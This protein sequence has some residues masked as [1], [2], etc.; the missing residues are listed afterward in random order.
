MAPRS[1]E[2]I[3]HCQVL[4]SGEKNNRGIVGGGKSL[5]SL[6]WDSAGSMAP[7]QEIQLQITGMSNKDWLARGPVASGAWLHRPAGGSIPRLAL[8]GKCL[9]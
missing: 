3:V 8:P 5:S 9:Q 4:K 1:M 2:F 7:A 6:S